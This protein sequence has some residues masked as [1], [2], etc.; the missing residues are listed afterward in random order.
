MAP[1]ER[2]VA[3]R[4]IGPLAR[5][6]QRDRRA[7]G[8]WLIAA[9]GQSIRHIDLQPLPGRL[10]LKL[11]GN[12]AGFS[13]TLDHPIPSPFALSPIDRSIRACVTQRSRPGGHLVFRLIR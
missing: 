10:A 4:I 3:T 1:A 5:F 7:Y 12:E 8:L 2:R 11:V 9:H 6:E 13:G